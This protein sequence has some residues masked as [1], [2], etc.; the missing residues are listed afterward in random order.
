MFNVSL[1]LFLS[2][3]IYYYYYSLIDILYPMRSWPYLFYSFLFDLPGRGPTRVWSNLFRQERG[4]PYRLFRRPNESG[5]PRIKDP[6]SFRGRPRVHSVS[7]TGSC[8]VRLRTWCP[9]VQ[10]PTRSQLPTTPWYKRPTY[11]LRPWG[12]MDQWVWPTVRI[13]RYTSNLSRNR[14]RF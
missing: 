12:T 7:T 8:T 10:L 2:N 14:S 4:K 11:W 3:Y 6:V 9:G 5:R 1:N 13:R